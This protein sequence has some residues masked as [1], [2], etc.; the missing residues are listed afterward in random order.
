MCLGGTTGSTLVCSVCIYSVCVCT[1]MYVYSLTS[2][3][4]HELQEQRA[5]RWS[6]THDIPIPTSNTLKTI[7]KYLLIQSRTD[8]EGEKRERRNKMK[9]RQK[10]WLY[11]MYFLL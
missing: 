10:G 6:L 1:L 2:N 5:H 11:E 4:F 8:R 7:F 9:A 3:T